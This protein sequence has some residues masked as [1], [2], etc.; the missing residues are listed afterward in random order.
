MEVITYSLRDGQKNSETFY[1]EV[2]VFAEEVLAEAERRVGGV[3]EAFQA[4]VQE[5]GR[6]ALRSRSEYTFELL[7]LGTFWR[8]YAQDALAL[9]RAPQ[10]TLAFLARL[11]RRGGVLKPAA[12]LLRGVLGNLFLSA[13]SRGLDSSPTLSLDHVDRLLDWLEAACDFRQELKRL[14]AWRDF[15]A[16]QEPESLAAVMDLAAWFE[17]RAEAV[18]GRYTPHVERFLRETHPGYRWREDEVFCGRRRVEYHLDMIGTQILN[19]AYREAFL[20]TARK[21]VLVPP[22]MKAKPDDQC[23]AHVT[24]YGARCAGCAPGCRVH[25]L[26]KFGEKYGFNVLIMPHELSVFSNGGVEPV[27]SGAVGVVGVSC[28][29]TN[30]P[31]GWETKDLG[32]PAQGVLLD[33]CGCRYHWHEQGIPTDINIAE[34]LRVLDVT[35]NEAK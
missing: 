21:V 32:V 13:H 33:Y 11:R 14:R 24:P 12:D 35:A 4:F 25:Q 7:N 30:P 1:K 18:L 19:C 6:E 15:L 26:T 27:A 2:A 3:L 31:G 10:R 20:E 17:T 5:T 29:L 23:Q 16:E 34:L 9:N 22:C 28:V 8:V